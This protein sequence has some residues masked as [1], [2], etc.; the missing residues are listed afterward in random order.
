MCSDKNAPCCQNCQFMSA[1]EK[2]R[3]AQLATCERESHCT[4]GS[5]EC[6]RSLAMTDGTPCL[7][8]G[9]CRGG[10]CVPYCETQGLQSCMCDVSKCTASFLSYCM[11]TFHIIV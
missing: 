11:S 2:C 1:Q 3:D 6:P 10:K 4:G 8:K 5:S 7:E 9:Q